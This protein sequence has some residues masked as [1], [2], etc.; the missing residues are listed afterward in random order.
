MIIRK[1]KKC[2]IGSERKL[3][4][5]FRR[6]VTHWRW[7]FCQHSLHGADASVFDVNG[8]YRQVSLVCWLHTC[9]AKKTLN[10]FWKCSFESICRIS[11]WWCHFQILTWENPKRQEI[12]QSPENYL[13]WLLCSLAWSQRSTPLISQMLSAVF[14]LLLEIIV[15]DRNFRVGM[16]FN[17]Q[18]ETLGQGI[19]GCKA[20]GAAMAI[21]QW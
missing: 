17:Y 1:K 20:W 18:S 12:T 16:D 4:W 19:R 13:H 11:P 8:I 2:L 3:V 21:Y 5:I 7:D 6:D 10:S 9:K 14:L 15:W